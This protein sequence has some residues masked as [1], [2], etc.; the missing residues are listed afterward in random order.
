MTETTVP[1]LP[2]NINQFNTVF[3]SYG[4]QHSLAFAR[5]L[6]NAF[7]EKGCSAWFDMNDIPLGVD[8][9]DQID[10]GIRRADN[11]IFIISPHSIQSV[12]CYKELAL[13]LKY[14]KRIVPVMHVEPQSDEDWKKID[15]EIGRRNW[16][17][18]KQ[19]HEAAIDLSAKAQQL[20]E[21]ILA[22]P[23]QEWKHIDNF[24]ESFALLLQLIESHKAFVY[25]H[26]WLLDKALLWHEMQNDTKKL[27]VGKERAQAEAFLQKSHQPFRNPTGHLINP[28]CIPTELMAYFVVESKKNS[29]NLQADLFICHDVDDIA[30]VEPIR[31]ALAQYG[32][33]SWISS[34]DIV[35]GTEYNQAIHGGVVK[36]SNLL[37][38]L[39]RRSL[40]SAY[41][42][43]E[44]NFALKYNKRIIP[45]LIEDVDDAEINESDFSGLA[46][47]QHINF[48]D[49]T[50]E[51]KV[52]IQSREDVKADVE[53]RSEKT[54]FEISLDEIVNT[55]NTNGS[56]HEQHRVFLA[57][58][59]R[60]K[61]KEQK[62]SF[63]LRGF[64][65]E[66]AQSWLRINKN[67]EQ[68]PPLQEHSEFITASLAAKGQLGTE[69][70]ISYSRKD[71][72]FARRLN[73]QL[74][75][76]GK[77][78][79]F[80][81][82]SISEGVNFEKEIFN[83]IAAA[84]NFVFVVS[85][86]SI[87]SEY[88]EREVNYA[89]QLNKRFIS[90]KVRE[91]EPEK[92]PEAL[93][94]INW[95][96][97]EGQDFDKTF[98]KLVQAIEIDR[99][100]AHL[101]TV[102]QQRA[103]EWFDN[104]QAD[105]YLLNAPAC[106][107]AEE[108]LEEAGYDIPEIPQ[109]LLLKEVREKERGNKRESL[110]GS[111]TRIVSKAL[112]NHY[113]QVAI[114][115]Y[116]WLL[117]WAIGLFFLTFIAEIEKDSY[118]AIALFVLIIYLAAVPVWF[119][120]KILPLELNLKKRKAF[121]QLLRFLVSIVGMLPAIFF[122][123][124]FDQI[125]VESDVVFETVLWSMA[126]FYA[127]IEMWLLFRSKKSR[128]R[129]SARAKQKKRG[130]LKRFFKN[131]Y[132]QVFL[133]WW[134]FKLIIPEG[135]GYAAGM[136]VFTIFY[137]LFFV[138]LR[139]YTRLN[140]QEIPKEKTSGKN[141]K[142][143]WDVVWVSI[144][145]LLSLFIG[146]LKLGS[147]DRAMK[148]EAI[149]LLFDYGALMLSVW[150]LLWLKRRINKVRKKAIYQTETVKELENFYSSV[151]TPKLPL[152]SQKQI[153]YIHESRIGIEASKIELNIIQR[154]LK[155][156]LAINRVLMLFSFGVLSLVFVL[157]ASLKFT[158][159]AKKDNVAH[160]LKQKIQPVDSFATE[161][162]VSGFGFKEIPEL[163][164]L[165]TLL[166]VITIEG[167]RLETVDEGIKELDKLRVLNLSRNALEELSVHV[168]ELPALEIMNL[169]HNVLPV[170]PGIEKSNF[171]SALTGSEHAQVDGKLFKCYNLR[172]LSLKDNRIEYIP[173][174]ISLLKSLRKLDVSVNMLSDVP[175]EIGKLNS[176]EILHLESNKLKSLPDEIKNLTSLTE[177]NVNDNKIEQ[178]PDNFYRLVQLKEL[179]L[180]NN[181]IGELSPEI[182]KFN[183]LKR[184]NL[185]RNNISVLPEELFKL[186]QLEELYLDGNPLS[187]EIIEKL[188]AE[189]PNTEVSF[190]GSYKSEY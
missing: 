158:R 23:E 114:G 13:A 143:L 28:P 161:L 177:L 108:W 50:N 124:L 32:F 24:E 103:S 62:T 154:R 25:E 59:L 117:V 56:Y 87:E 128:Q 165:D 93:R 79:W 99:E 155:Q 178:L 157:S 101:H 30:V 146:A 83:G 172:E 85:P 17:Q 149:V 41:C 126:Y 90:V 160:F 82:E 22:I 49:L 45:I 53:A 51:V 92:M 67:R 8:F 66:N 176:L 144:G 116:A 97:F 14:N 44:Y 111:I 129:R 12:Y 137:V 11:F 189:L 36:S 31:S 9:Q 109:D 186:K 69:V 27:L 65:L 21:E 147:I 156:R 125:L 38:F 133:L 119:Y 135:A 76:N 151:E 6:Y 145:L 168:V 132:V 162:N 98:T 16:V 71:S 40:K 37:L 5:K 134:F 102:M 20:K 104:R 86:D 184:L 173:Q 170:F 105:D 123:S 68:Y 58:A 188:R 3:I 43:K 142:L 81:Q 47:I 166:E 163:V 74:Q 88:C 141:R 72:D 112:Q 33:S 29:S 64:N 26:T 152:V 171:F 70:F 179:D 120:S 131:I 130:R 4:R 39:S 75:I 113:V 89:A 183:S 169:D 48:T 148:P 164:Y 136:L 57:Q 118:T 180:G 2:Q 52:E 7:L 1:E 84:D 100:H 185:E 60:W 121:K 174:Y 54:P 140:A 181:K 19:E 107:K 167:C 46:L 187:D 115:A 175:E 91:P 127:L 61:E 182:G 77:T 63:L 96:D 110:F 94:L 106:A 139:V 153:T 35:K 15:P 138:P 78:T 34:K 150:G 55:L 95:I 73:E 159:T 42:L 122:F 18:M 80:D 190:F 10:E